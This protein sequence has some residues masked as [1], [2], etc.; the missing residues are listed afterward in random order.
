MNKAPIIFFGNQKLVQGIKKDVATITDILQAAGH[1]TIATITNKS[2][3]EQLSALLK[4]YPNSVGILASFGYIVPQEVI[5]LFEPLGILNIHPSILPKYRGP[6]PIETA[7]LNGDNQTGVSIMKISKSMDAGDIYTQ[8]S[9][10][11]SPDD[12]KF[13]LCD[14]LT[15]LGA[16]MLVQVLDNT[17]KPTKQDHTQATFTQKLDKSMALL[18]PT[19]SAT[20]LEREVRAFLSFPRSR[21]TLR[22]IDCIITTAH[23]SDTPQTPDIDLLC[24]DGK[25]LCIDR[26]IPANSR[27]M[28]IQAFLLGH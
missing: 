24:S 17:P 19:K 4:Q 11:T 9:I 28:A 18:D 5:D 8:Q 25:Y 20:Q 7:I 3:Y 1:E 16:D 13:T 27:D 10:D 14:R 15:R 26:L 23:V 12:N 22:D 21:I 6:T 2:G